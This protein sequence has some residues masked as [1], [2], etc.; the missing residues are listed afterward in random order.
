MKMDK[1]PAH[2][3]DKQK[4][5]RIVEFEDEFISNLFNCFEVPDS[6]EGKDFFK[7][8]TAKCSMD[9]IKRNPIFR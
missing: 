1:K 5:R 7:Q 9:A 8:I 4:V 6:V 3:F 2:K